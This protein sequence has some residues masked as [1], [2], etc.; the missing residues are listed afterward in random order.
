[1][2]LQTQQ[3]LPLGWREQSPGTW[4]AAFGIV[5]R[6][7]HRHTAFQSCQSVR[8]PTVL[9]VTEAAVEAAAEAAGVHW[10]GCMTM[11]ALE[12]LEARQVWEH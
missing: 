6:P 12:P 11:A 8:K 10:P 7:A 4:T 1:M 3:V 2:Y 5:L 9:A